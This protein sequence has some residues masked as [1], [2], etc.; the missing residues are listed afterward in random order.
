MSL[1]PWE[2]LRK[3]SRSLPHPYVYYTYIICPYH[4]FALLASALLD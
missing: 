3:G 4:V 2:V 1:D